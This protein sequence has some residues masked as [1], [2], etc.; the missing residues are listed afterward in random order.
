MRHEYEVAH[1]QIGRKVWRYQ[2]LESTNT[3]AL[4]LAHDARYHGLAIWADTQT[5]G[6]GRLGRSWVSEPGA[7]ALLSVLVFPPPHLRRPVTM[8]AWAAVAVCETVY[9]TISRQPRIKWPND[10]LV[11]GRKVCG[12]LVE[13]SHGTVVGIGLNVNTSAEFFAQHGLT[14]AGSLRCLTQRTFDVATIGE[15]LLDRLDAGYASLVEGQ[16]EEIEAA[17]RWYSGLWG[18]EVIL[19]LNNGER[20]RGR[21]MEMSFDGLVLVSEGEPQLFVPEEVAEIV[22]GEEQEDR[23][24]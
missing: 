4:S 13:Q 24:D 21:L 3:L 20:H 23:W 2:V 12:I 10:V 7:G 19:H 9:Q 16:T 22:R 8:T 5:A 14:Q 15:L 18:R 6:R 17:W 1:R 11:A